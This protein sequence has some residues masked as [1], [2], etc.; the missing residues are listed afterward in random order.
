MV[1]TV[2]PLL[3]DACVL[4]KKKMVN[5]R[6]KERME[7]WIAPSLTAMNCHH[8]FFTLEEFFSSSARIGFGGVE[9]WTSPQHF[10]YGL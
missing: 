6:M 2:T 1:V 10:L 3:R 9:I 8:R 5:N 7:E 4:V